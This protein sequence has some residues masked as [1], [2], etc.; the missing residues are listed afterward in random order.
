MCVFGPERFPI[1]SPE[2]ERD[3]DARQEFDDGPTSVSERRVHTPVRNPAA[4]RKENIHTEEPDTEKIILGDLAD[5]EDGDMADVSAIKESKVDEKIVSQAILGRDLYDVYSNARVQLAIERQSADHMMK[6][7]NAVPEVG[8]QL[9]GVIGG[10]SRI[11]RSTPPEVGVLLTGVE[12]SSRLDSTDVA[13]LLSPERVGLACSKFGL[14]QGVA[15]DIKSGY[16]FDVAADRARC[17]HE[18]ME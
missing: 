7:V 5:E 15:M 2:K 10:Q 9:T 18:I 16:D 12:E 6:L 3:E 11:K 13:D 1:G 4:K 8:D 17:W 14:V